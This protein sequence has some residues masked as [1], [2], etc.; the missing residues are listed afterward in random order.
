MKPEEAVELIKR[1]AKEQYDNDDEDLNIALNV[2]I[3][4]LYK[5]FPHKVEK[6]IVD[7]QEASGYAETCPRC[8]VFVYDNYCQ[9]CGQKLNWV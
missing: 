1:I 9:H 8:H 3:Q 6:K 4:A 7:N 5:Q 2:A